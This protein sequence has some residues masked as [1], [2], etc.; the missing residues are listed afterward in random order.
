MKMTKDNSSFLPSS[1]LSEPKHK[2]LSQTYTTPKVKKKKS[3]K[4][5]LS[6]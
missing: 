3:K 6:P 5:K 2:R 4:V 1:A